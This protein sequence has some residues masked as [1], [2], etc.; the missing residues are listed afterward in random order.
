M[1]RPPNVWEDY[2]LENRDTSGFIN[3]LPGA[4]PRQ[5]AGSTRGARGPGGINGV[6]PEAV[7]SEP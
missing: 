3:L 5:F 6:S 4:V 7:T 1:R 2:P